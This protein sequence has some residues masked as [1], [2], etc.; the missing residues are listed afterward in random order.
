MKPGRKA[1]LIARPVWSGPR[2]KRN[3]APAPW[4][5]RIS[6]R[7]GTPSRVPRSV[8]TSSLRASFWDRGRGRRKVARRGRRNGAGDRSAREPRPP[9][10]RLEEA[11]V[12]LV[13]EDG[14]RVAAV[15]EIVDAHERA[16]DQR[17]ETPG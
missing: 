6:R 8:S 13:H 1:R 9:R 17:P 10:R 3:V 14:P 4:R 7:R 2:L 16:R 12:A 15:E 5:F 11:R